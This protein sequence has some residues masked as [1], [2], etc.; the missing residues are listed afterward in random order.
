MT[1]AFAERGGNA[2]RQTNKKKKG[3][4]RETKENSAHVIRDNSDGQET[5]TTPRVK[6]GDDKKARVSLCYAER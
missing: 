2:N 4:M 3:R 6:L 1:C 5:E